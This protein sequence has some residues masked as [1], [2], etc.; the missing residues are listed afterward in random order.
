VT[1]AGDPGP[2]VSVVVPTLDRPERAAEVVSAVLAAAEQPAE[3]LVVDQSADDET[4][5]AL[6]RLGSD[7]VRHVRH[8]PPSTSGARNEGARLAR[9]EYV[10]F[11]DDDVG[12][13]PG[14]LASMRAELVRL[15]LPDAV[16]GEVRPPES[17]T[18]GRSTLPVSIF[19]PE[20]ARV[21]DRPVH[22]NRLGYGANCVVR[23]SVFLAAGGFDPRLGPGTRLCGAEDMDLGYRFLKAGRRVA[24]TP[25]FSIVH[26]QWRAPEELPRL[27]Y[28]YNVG[29]AAFCAKHLRAG[30]LRALRF[31]LVQVGGDAKMFASA[32]KRRSLLRARVAAARTA[33]T[34]NGLV[35]GLRELG[36]EPA[37]GSSPG[38]GT[39]PGFPPRGGS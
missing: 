9:G 25:A 22:P 23:R 31:F 1:A 13:G 38:R 3:I 11:L 19:R 14:W 35:R 18:P 27:F 28:G 6:E 16:Y 29:G 32:V 30:D 4:R 10:A 24:S 5:L 20:E 39:S 21:W 12:I 7:L 2:T 15:G 8:G 37:R 34:W 26:E 36:G 17:F 33:G